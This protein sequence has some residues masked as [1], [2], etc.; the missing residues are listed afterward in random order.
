M[1]L[2]INQQTPVKKKAPSAPGI[3]KWKIHASIVKA[4]AKPPTPKT[5]SQ[6]YLF[7]INHRINAPMPISTIITVSF[8]LGS[9]WFD[10][11]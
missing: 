11:T 5:K 7:V 3:W 1:M 8:I 2:A 4:A 10:K 6:N 9:P